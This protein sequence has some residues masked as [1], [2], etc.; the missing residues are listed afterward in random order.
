MERPN[1]APSSCRPDERRSRCELPTEWWITGSPHGNRAFGRVPYGNG[2]RRE[3]AVNPY[4]GPGRSTGGDGG[5][6]PAEAAAQIRFLE[7]EVALQIGRAS[8]RERG[9]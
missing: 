7:E 6:D 3:D 1:A 9:W 2:A 8:C 4:D 5:H